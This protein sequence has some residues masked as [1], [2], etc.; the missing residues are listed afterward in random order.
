VIVRIVPAAWLVAAVAEHWAPAAVEVV[1]EITV[2]P[3]AQVLELALGFTVMRL[4]V[5]VA[6]E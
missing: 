5:V 6:H 3:A 2:T 1:H 4:H